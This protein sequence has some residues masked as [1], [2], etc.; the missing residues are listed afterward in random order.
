[1]SSAGRLARSGLRGSLVAGFV[2]ALP[3][4]G[5]APPPAEAR[6]S[7]VSGTYVYADLCTMP[8]DGAQAGRRITLKRWP[9][10]DNLVYEGAGL[11][12]PI[13]TAVVIDDSTKD[14]AFHVETSAGLVSFR[15]TAGSDALVGT[16]HGAD[17]SQPLRLKRV[18]RARA[19]ET[20]SG[21]TTGSIN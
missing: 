9:K 4:A 5:L 1:M 11:P 7:W 18:L 21:E 14:V 8:A 16:L 3:L 6:T 20:C 15:G 19:Q 10:G 17:G 2:A 13:E 12:A